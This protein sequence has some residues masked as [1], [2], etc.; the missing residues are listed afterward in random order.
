MFV[1]VSPH[2]YTYRPHLPV[3]STSLFPMLQKLVA[4]M[5]YT[6]EQARHLVHDAATRHQVL[7][8][9][10]HLILLMSTTALG[11]CPGA[12]SEPFPSVK[13]SSTNH[14]QTYH[15][16]PQ[17]DDSITADMHPSFNETLQGICLA[18][19]RIFALFS[20]LVPADLVPAAGYIGGCGSSMK[21]VSS[22][23]RSSWTS[24]E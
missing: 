12:V 5:D 22:M 16:I 15:P 2:I 23:R 18:F 3:R 19:F 21:P 17:W 8:N 4:T 14:H 24:I 1:H 6:P 7:T 13:G 10:P 20:N 11:T 9:I